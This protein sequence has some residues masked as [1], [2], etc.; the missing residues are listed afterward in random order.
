MII[1]LVVMSLQKKCFSNRESLKYILSFFF[2]AIKKSDLNI[3]LRDLINMQRDSSCA[4]FLPR[5]L[6][7]IDM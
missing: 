3:L 1:T 7:G 2:V 6:S 4:G 5:T